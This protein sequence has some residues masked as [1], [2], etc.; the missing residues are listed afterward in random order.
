MA[1]EPQVGAIVGKLPSRMEGF[2]LWW[3]R[4]AKDGGQQEALLGRELGGAR[5]KLA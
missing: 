1:K 5:V 3:T 4:E 2:L